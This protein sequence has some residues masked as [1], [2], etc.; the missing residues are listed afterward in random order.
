MY[1]TPHNTQFIYRTNL[2]MYP[3]TEI[4]VLKKEFLDLPPEAQF[5]KG[6]IDKVGFIKMKMFALRKTLNRL[7]KQATDWGENTCKS[8]I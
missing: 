6:K 7:K 2:H 4:K 5:I 1:T 8:H 3:E